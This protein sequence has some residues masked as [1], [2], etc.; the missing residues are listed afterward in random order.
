MIIGP[1]DFVDITATVDIVSVGRHIQDKR[2]DVHF[3]FTRVVRLLA[4]Q[5]L[6]MVRPCA[7]IRSTKVD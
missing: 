2:T 7:Q 3:A 6:I 5:D 4:A 1:G